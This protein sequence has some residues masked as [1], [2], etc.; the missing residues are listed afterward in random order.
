MV[1][2]YDVPA[3]ALIHAVA[4][5]LDE[6]LDTPDWIQYAKSGS[7]RE[8]PPQQDDFW[9]VR[10]A[11]VLRKLATDGPVGV[12]RLSTE[13]GGRAGGSTRYR[14]AAEHRAD[15]S[16]KV[17]RTILQQLEEEGLVESAGGEGRRITGE[18]RALL[19]D[20][21]GEVLEDLDRPDLERYA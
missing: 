15:G 3:D 6:R 18:G 19:D 2:L 13:Y 9:A 12:E 20:V 10:A 5:D 21:A 16:K 14:V 7:S 8:L 11:S 1:T 4:E 17:L